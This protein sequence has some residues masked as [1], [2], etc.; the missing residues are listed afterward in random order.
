MTPPDNI[1]NDVKVFILLWKDVKKKIDIDSEILSKEYN[2]TK[3]EIDCE[4][5]SYTFIIDGILYKW[6]W[7]EEEL[8]K[9]HTPITS[10]PAYDYAIKNNASVRDAYHIVEDEMNKRGWYYEPDEYAYYIT[11]NGWSTMM[12]Y[13]CDSVEELEEFDWSAEML[14]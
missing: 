2:V 7:D 12:P 4:D 5:G 9:N 11:K 3:E 8:Y 10:D 13:F 14:E 6:D 1:L